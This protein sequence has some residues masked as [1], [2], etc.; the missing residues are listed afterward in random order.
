MELFVSST[1]KDAARS[2]LFESDI[3]NAVQITRRKLSV[4]HVS[5]FSFQKYA[6]GNVL[7]FM[8][9]TYSKQWQDH[10]IDC[11]FMEAD[12]IV[13]RANKSNAPFFWSELKNHNFF[14]VRKQ[15][16]AAVNGPGNLGYT[17]PIYRSSNLCAM[18]SLSDSGDSTQWQESLGGLGD[19]M[20]VLGLLIHTKAPQ[21]LVMHYKDVTLSPR[22]IECLIWTA[23]GKD[24]LTVS[25]ILGI[26]EHTG[27]DYLKSART[28]LGCASIAQAVYI[29]TKMGIIDY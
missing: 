24:A 6:S 10:Y 3:E 12:P 19:L 21:D 1:I 16:S 8:S 23:K 20:E 2:I 5:Y 15:L 25:R 27:R 29:G 4:R 13:D 7:Q 17:V 22:E 11:N 26:S 28:K 18:F 9:A 14:E